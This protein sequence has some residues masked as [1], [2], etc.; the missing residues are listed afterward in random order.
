MRQILVDMK[1]AADLLST[2]ERS[3]Q[4]CEKAYMALENDLSQRLSQITPASSRQQTQMAQLQAYLETIRKR[5][6]NTASLHD[7]VPFTL[8][9]VC[10]NPAPNTL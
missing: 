4:S 8:R 6:Q 7:K 5:R 9:R 2:T 3:L 10:G 1:H